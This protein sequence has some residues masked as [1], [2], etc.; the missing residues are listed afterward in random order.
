MAL[1][2]MLLPKEVATVTDVN[3][4]KGEIG[5]DNVQANMEQCQRG[6]QSIFDCI[7]HIAGLFTTSY[8]G[9]RVSGTETD[10]SEQVHRETE[11]RTVCCLHDG[12][13]RFS[14]R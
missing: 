1:L 2:R 8:A 7:T 6:L 13:S 5:F 9:T 4:Q 11:Y 10:A 14:T 12:A 3:L